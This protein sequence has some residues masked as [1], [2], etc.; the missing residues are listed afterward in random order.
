MI[1]VD[2]NTIVYYWINGD[3]THDAVKAFE[4]DPEWVA[5]LLWKTELRNVLVGYLRRKQI[6]FEDILLVLRK[7]EEQFYEHE[8][9]IPS[10]QVIACAN[11]SECSAYDCEY[12]ALALDLGLQLVTSDKKIL[13][14]FPETAVHLHE[15]APG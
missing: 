8:F 2:V 7:T 4:K 12:V 10:H 11:R 14:N 9:S 13:R 1:V 6:S 5:P 15:F 3:F